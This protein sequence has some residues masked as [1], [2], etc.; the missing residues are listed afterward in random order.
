MSSS[1]DAATRWTSLVSVA[2]L[3][4]SRAPLPKPGAW[5]CDALATDGD[6]PGTG[7][8]RAAAASR[9]WLLAGARSAPTALPESQ[10]APPLP[11][12]VVAEDAAWRLGRMLGG[13]RRELV[14]EWFDL[15]TRAGAVLPPHWLPTVFEKL[16]AERCRTFAVVLGAHATWLAALNPR[17]SFSVATELPSD[18]S[19]TSGTLQE[20]RAALLELRR[21]DPAR[22]RAWVES[23]WSED[24]PDARTAFVELFRVGLGLDDEPLLEHALDDRRKSV[25]LAAADCLARLPGSA[26]ARRQAERLRP[27]VRL[28][29]SKPG[30]L[31]KL[32]SRRLE[33]DLPESLE[34]AAIRDGIEPK[35]P[36]QRKIGERT[37]W[38]VQMISMTRPS[39][40]SEIFSCDAAGFIDAALKTDYASELLEALVAATLR[41]PDETW[42][43]ALGERLI[44]RL[45]KENAQRGMQHLAALL[46]V[47]PP[48]TRDLILGRVIQALGRTHFEI[49]R[50]IVAG[51]DAPWS[52]E[53]TLDLCR[54]LAETARKDSQQ[55]SHPRTALDDWG[56]RADI[57][58][59]GRALSELLEGLPAV[60]PWRN[61]IEEFA[62]TIAFRAAM[63]KELLP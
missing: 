53:M 21:R 5:P 19:W 11:D 30:L 52:R 28:P 62:E 12:R 59:T 29:A 39:L 10:S 38:L 20:R 13:E 36:A 54:V 7:L 61:A 26:L 58:V 15:A 17:W 23:T 40:W 47:A 27:L 3:G 49:V 34:K 44:P 60:S 42:V 24:P 63:R 35:P 14:P 56:L 18:D 50:G 46:R 9:L 8:L 1:V 51:L 57:E 41:N 48:G 33:I 22:A 16:D 2:T 25:R 55:W 31:A 32:A 45:E 6:E 43:A 4:V 37:Y